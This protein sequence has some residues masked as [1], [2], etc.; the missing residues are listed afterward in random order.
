MVLY[1]YSVVCYLGV[2]SGTEQKNNASPFLPWMSNKAAK[3]LIALTPEMVCEET[4][5]GLL[6]VTSALFLIAKFGIWVSRI[7]MRCM[8]H[9]RG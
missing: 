5:M 7:N 2:L 6:P 8:L 3:Q 1:L 9:L 4:A